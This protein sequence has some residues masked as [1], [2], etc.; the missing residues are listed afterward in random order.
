[1]VR[2]TV[3]SDITCKDKNNASSVSIYISFPWETN[4]E[5][6]Q[7]IVLILNSRNLCKF[8]VIQRIATIVDKFVRGLQ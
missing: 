4:T 2:L 8:L 7:L 3:I 6:N 1:M 5:L